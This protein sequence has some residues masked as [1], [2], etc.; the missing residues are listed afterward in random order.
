MR[1]NSRLA[2]GSP[3]ARV[4][5][6]MAATLLAA[7]IVVGASIAGAQL[8][9]ADGPIVVDQSGDGDYTTIGEAVAAAEDGDEIL[10]RPG[11]YI[12]AVVIDK[13]IAVSGEGSVEDIVIMA[14]EDGPTAPLYEGTI[15]ADPYAML[16]TGPGAKI[17]GLTFR[18]L[19]SEV[20][21]DGGSPT[22][23]DSVFTDVGWAFDGVNISANGSSIVVTNGGSPTVSGN[24]IRSGGPIAVFG[25]ANATL[26]SNDLAGGPHI[27]L[28]DFGQ[29]V[30]IEDNSIDGTLAWAIGAF[31]FSGRVMIEGNV[32]TN[33]GKNGINLSQG[34]ADITGNEV[35]GASLAGIATGLEPS[36]VVGNT[37]VD[38]QIAIS[39]AFADGSVSDNVVRGGR[40]GIVVSR[41]L[42][43]SGNDVEGVERRGIAVG[44]GSP[45][46]RDNRSCGNGENLFVA[47]L[48][49]PDIDDSNDLC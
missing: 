33:P 48:A 28:A 9:A 41:D 35:S 31:D 44:G 32:I 38:N 21:L 45:V 14:P 30:V 5:A 3:T 34:S 12:E 7:P 18:G 40:A 6:I 1:T 49:D 47:E 24:V 39:A 29:E 25:D 11:T 8:L 13:N 2:V 17:S 26:R 36:N 42:E 37:L 23:Q 19:R 43:V 10:V 22:L 15:T 16:V 46:L 20:I 4:A 27:Y